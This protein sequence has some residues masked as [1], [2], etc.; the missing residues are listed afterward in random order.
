MADDCSFFSFISLVFGIHHYHFLKMPSLCILSSFKIQI[1]LKAQKIIHLK[2]SE[3]F[4]ALLCGTMSFWEGTVNWKSVIEKKKKDIFFRFDSFKNTIHKLYKSC[5]KC[6]LFI[7][8][9]KRVNAVWEVPTPNMSSSKTHS[10][11]LLEENL[12]KEQNWKCDLTNQEC[13]SL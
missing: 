5:T 2:I 12:H 8:I 6:T 3:F 11:L 10:K 13:V 4:F 1:F 7:F 9:Y